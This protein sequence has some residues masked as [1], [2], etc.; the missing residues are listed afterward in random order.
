MMI[1]VSHEDMVDV[2]VAM[3]NAIAWAKCTLGPIVRFLTTAFLIDGR[4]QC[5]SHLVDE[6]HLH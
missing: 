1:M 6:L 3:A 4:C 2:A 5:Q